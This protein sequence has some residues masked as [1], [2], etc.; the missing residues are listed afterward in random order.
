LKDNRPLTYPA[1]LWIGLFVLVC[2]LTPVRFSGTF[3]DLPYQLDPDEP[4]FME[5]AA[6]MAGGHLFPNR[7]LIHPAS[8]TV[9]TLAV[10]Y[11]VLVWHGKSAGYFQDSKGFFE[12]VRQQPGPLLLVGRICTV[13]V[14]VLVTVCLVF[15]LHRLGLDPW[16]SLAGG[17]LHALS[18]LYLEFSR[19]VRADFWLTLMLLLSLHALLTVFRRGLTRDYL[20]AGLFLGLATACKYGAVVGFALVPMVHLMAGRFY[21]EPDGV[22]PT[23]D[24]RRRVTALVV[25]GVGLALAVHGWTWQHQW[26]T[27]LPFSQFPPSWRDGAAFIKRQLVL[28]GTVVVLIGLSIPI[29]GRISRATLSVLWDRRPYLLGVAAVAGFLAT[30]PDFL[31]RFEIAVQCIVLFCKSYHPRASGS[32]GIGNALYYLWGPMASDMGI[33]AL[34]SSLIVLILVVWRGAA[35]HRL[36]AGF[37]ALYFGLVC[38]GR[39]RWDRYILPL[40]PLIAAGATM[41]LFQLNRALA[42]TPARPFLMLLATCVVFGEPFTQAIRDVSCRLPDS[43]VVATEWFLE[44][45][46]PKCRVLIEEHAMCLGT[47]PFAVRD[48]FSIVDDPRALKPGQYDYIV[49]SSAVRGEEN[50]EETYRRLAATYP[51]RMRFSPSDGTCRGATVTIYN[52]SSPRPAAPVFNGP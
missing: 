52:A 1:S 6:F 49:T 2:L 32:P 17:S 3:Q 39:A 26:L 18:S 22:D 24:Y 33:V 4:L 11:R 47:N 25:V 8:L 38:L 19:Q 30:T 48:V 27:F 9:E 14:G 44:N 37:A 46:R 5:P 21:R 7:M 40:S 12:K 15:L 35:E 34:L 45:A 51:V 36:I 41:A 20:L 43:Q 13:W 42:R 31:A 16:A 29:R 23:D 10:A 50:W 28:M